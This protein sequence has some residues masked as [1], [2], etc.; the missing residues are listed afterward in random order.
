MKNRS[1]SITLEIVL[2]L[3]LKQYI[4]DNQYVVI[5]YSC[6][7]SDTDNGFRVTEYN[8]CNPSMGHIMFTGTEEEC[9]DELKN[10]LAELEPASNIFDGT[11]DW[12]RMEDDDQLQAYHD[13]YPDIAD[14]MMIEDNHE[15]SHSMY[16]FEDY[17]MSPLASENMQ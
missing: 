13:R 1:A 6:Y 11:P 14:D 10:I 8:N 7:M 12:A 9:Q 16:D 4:M 3:K 15:D 17:P 2:K 5:R